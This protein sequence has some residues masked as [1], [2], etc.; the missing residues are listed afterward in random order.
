VHTGE[1]GFFKIRIRRGDGFPAVK[2]TAEQIDGITHWF[3]AAWVID[4]EDGRP[5][6]LGE[7]A[8]IPDPDDWPRDAPHWIASGDLVPDGY[9]EPANTEAHPIVQTADGPWEITG[10][11]DGKLFGRPA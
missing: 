8:M 3:M 2:P 7:H 6:Y 5:E 10:E 9:A 1:K 4:E 11:A